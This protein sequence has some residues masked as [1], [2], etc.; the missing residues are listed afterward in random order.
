VTSFGPAG[1][2]TDNYTAIMRERGWTWD[3]LA[4]D[5][6]RQ[7]QQSSLDGGASA[8]SM[9]RW[10]RANADAGRERREAAEDPLRPD[11]PAPD[12]ATPDPKKRT[13]VP[14]GAPARRDSAVAV[15]P[16]GVTGGN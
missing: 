10:A 13:A 9:A 7:A 8:L 16:A 11:P 1:D 3:D 6:E 14:K 15:T 12:H 5:F 4:D 2:V